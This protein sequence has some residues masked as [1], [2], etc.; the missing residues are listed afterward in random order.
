MIVGSSLQS[1]AGRDS[2][3]VRQIDKRNSKMMRKVSITCGIIPRLSRNSSVRKVQG[4][5]RKKSLRL[6]PGLRA[7]KV[8]QKL[9]DG[10]PYGKPDRD[11]AE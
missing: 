7:T 6:D 5:V 3:M 4:E 2:N 10:N 9:L 8:C 1:N 11:R